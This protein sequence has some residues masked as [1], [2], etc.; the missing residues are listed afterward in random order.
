MAQ[1]QLRF[2]FQTNTIRTKICWIS[3]FVHM[4]NF[5][6]FS[7]LFF[8]FSSVFLCYHMSLPH[9]LSFLVLFIIIKKH[10]ISVSNRTIYWFPTSHPISVTQYQSI[11]RC[12]YHSA[13]SSILQRHHF[14]FCILC[15]CVFFA[16][17]CFFFFVCSF[18]F[19]LLFYFTFHNQASITNNF[20]FSVT[21]VK[22]TSIL[23]CN[24]KG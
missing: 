10:N 3:L 9:V 1:L 7:L 8:H 17:H 4:L 16:P 22:H 12:K 18:F 6:F 19:F 13:I 23:W 15:S 2:T 21:F 24:V 14:I 11:C 20:S 5:H